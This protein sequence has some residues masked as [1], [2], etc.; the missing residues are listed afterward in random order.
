M[1]LTSEELLEIV[2][3]NYEQDDIH[4]YP[5]YFS[6]DDTD[7]TKRVLEDIAVRTNGVYSSTTTEMPATL[8]AIGWYF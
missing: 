7:E 2:G 6:S 8:K 5:I 4:I 1:S 3:V